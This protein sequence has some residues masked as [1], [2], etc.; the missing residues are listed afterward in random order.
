MN[1][2]SSL[3]DNLGVKL[4][5]VVVALFIWFNASGQ[6][7]A[8]R[9]RMIPLVFQNLPDSLMIAGPVPTEVEVRLSTTRRQL[10]TM[11]F[12]RVHV[13]VDMSSARPG[14]QRIALSPSNLT[15]LPSGVDRR[16]VTVISPAMLDVEVE[17]VESRRV[18][19]ALSTSGAVPTEFVL[20]DGG[21]VIN[22]GWV[23]I[24]GPA[25]TV[26][27]LKNVTTQTLD[28]SKVRESV[29]RE[30]ALD[31]DPRLV[32]CTPEHVVVSLRVSERSERV[33]ANLPP[34]VLVD[35]EDVDAEV[36]PTTVSLTVEGP[37]AVLD[38]LSSGDV[39]IL[40]NLGG[41]KPATYTLAPEIILPPGVTLAGTSTD[42][43]V[44]RIT[45]TGDPVDGVR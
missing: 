10:L 21:P 11:G 36:F 13:A 39:S 26:L 35:S 24:R 33:L 4:I 18:P 43:L 3:T 23:T 22:P 28:L 40:I 30:V 16:N 20:L 15:R 19:V 6:E 44:V 42:S 14:R 37:A 41:M 17:R 8:V 27:R 25:S 45:R 31:Y 32:S 38:T 9:L 12:K 34:T 29:E 7:E 2:K 5:A 1:L